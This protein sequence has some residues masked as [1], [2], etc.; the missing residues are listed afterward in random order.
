MEPFCAEYE[1]FV[2]LLR[3]Y[4]TKN[5]TMESDALWAF[6]GVISV[7][8]RASSP[9]TADEDPWTLQ[10]MLFICA[11]NWNH[12]P[13]DRGRGIMDYSRRPPVLRR[14]GFSSWSWAGWKRLPDLWRA[15][16]NPS[17]VFRI[18]SLKIRAIEAASVEVIR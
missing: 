7:F 12:D 4:V 6:R 1:L 14:S 10:K 18:P 13:F 15:G 2:S 5:L 16:K 9:N 3:V 17:G 11:L 8:S